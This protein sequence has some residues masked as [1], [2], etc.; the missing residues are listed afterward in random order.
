MASQDHRVVITGVGVVSPFGRGLDALWQ[1]LLRGDTAVR[2]RDG[3]PPAARV[4][5]YS[6]PAN[7]DADAASRLGRCALLAT[8]AAI[9]A[10]EDARLPV[11]AQSAPL[12]GVSFGSD[13]GEGDSAAAGDL[14]TSVARVL[15]V[16]GPVISHRGPVSGASAIAEAAELIRRGAAPV[17]VAGGADF[18]SAA[19]LAHT[20]SHLS[21]A[22]AVARPFDRESDGA[23]PGEGAAAF[24]LEDEAL[25]R[26]RGARVYAELL[27]QGTAFSRATVMAP[28]MNSVDAARAMQAALFRAEILQGEIDLV[29]DSAAGDSVGDAVSAK[30]LRELWGPNVDRLTVTSVHGGIGHASSAAAPLALAA[31][32]RAL[33]EGLVPPTVGCREVDPAFS[34]LDIVLGEPRRLRFATALVNAFSAGSNVS[35]ILRRA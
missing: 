17:V 2:Q 4:E 25:A 22:R 10:I 18:L 19:G 11:T 8:D 34:D 15:G 35:L 24:V 14:A 31:T 7:L 29:S 28:A 30:A 32:L 12:I 23:A 6:P 1:A 21:L 16:A 33:V 13:H 27:G 9:Q 20:P 3:E 5:A 26:E